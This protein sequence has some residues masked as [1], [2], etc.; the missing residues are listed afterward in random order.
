MTMRRSIG[1]VAAGAGTLA[2]VVALA[3][4]LGHWHMRSLDEH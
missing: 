3:F 1:W 4:F 2:G